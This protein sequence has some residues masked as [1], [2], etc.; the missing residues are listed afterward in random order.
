MMNRTLEME[1]FTDNFIS[2]SISICI[3]VICLILVHHS[4]LPSH[5][6]PF[7]TSLKGTGMR[8]MSGVRDEARH[9]RDEPSDMRDVWRNGSEE[10]ST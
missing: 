6:L 9:G 1:D 10:R 2:L 8:R 4:S 5:L 3:S 7:L